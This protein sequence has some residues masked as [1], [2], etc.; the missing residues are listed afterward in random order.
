MN[1]Q[2]ENNSGKKVDE[3]LKKIDDIE[4]VSED[5]LND[6][7]FYELAYYMQN[8]NIIDSLNQEDGE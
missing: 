8:L 7:D 6:M 1:N 3:L 2:N 4:L 5:E